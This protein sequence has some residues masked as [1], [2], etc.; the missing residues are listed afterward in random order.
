MYS[1]HLVGL[2][3]VEQKRA[4]CYIDQ[5]LWSRHFWFGIIVCCYTSQTAP[6]KAI[7]QSIW[8][9]MVKNIEIRVYVRIH[10][11]RCL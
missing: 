4:Q 11:A 5:Y 10:Q 1:L 6:R 9:E 2:V 8:N 3:R 7:H